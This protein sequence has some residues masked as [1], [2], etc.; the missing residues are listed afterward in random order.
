MRAEREYCL[1]GLRPHVAHVLMA[2]YICRIVS[3]ERRRKLF[4]DFVEWTFTS[5]LLFS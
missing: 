4:M 2:D 1:K 5:V 3:E